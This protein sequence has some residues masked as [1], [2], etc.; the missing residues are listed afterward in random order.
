VRSCNGNVVG[1]FWSIETTGTLLA[2]VCLIMIFYYSAI[3]WY[4]DYAAYCRLAED[5]KKVMA[6]VAQLG[7]RQ[8]VLKK[9]RGE[10]F[11]EEVP[12][13]A[14]PIAGWATAAGAFDL[15]AGG[16]AKVYQRDS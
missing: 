10:P 11:G 14:C 2:S 15:R 6:I 1:G 16:G 12:D 9:P 3:A 7:G 8:P 4:R 5:G 13:S